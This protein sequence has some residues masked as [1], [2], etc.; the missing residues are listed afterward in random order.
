M[1]KLQNEILNENF[2]K[3][4]YFGAFAQFLLVIGFSL[5]TAN[6]LCDGEQRE[7]IDELKNKVEMLEKAND[8]DTPMDPRN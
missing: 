3:L 8:I 6:F 5:I 2:M 1:R 4:Y 7:E